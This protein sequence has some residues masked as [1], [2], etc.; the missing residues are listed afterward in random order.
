[1]NIG[2]ISD[3][4]SNFEALRA[5]LSF[6][7][8]EKVEQVICAGDIIGYGAEPNECIETIK[9]VSVLNVYGNHEA[10]LTGLLP[11]E[12][13]NTYAKEAIDWHRNK[14]KTDNFD[15]IHEL[16]LEAVFDKFIKIVH[17]SPVRPQQ[18]PYLI[19]EREYAEALIS[20]REKICIVGHTHAPAVFYYDAERYHFGEISND[21]FLIEGDFK[22]II[23]VGSVGQPRDGDKR[24]CCGIYDYET[25]IFKIRRVEYDFM[26]ARNKIIKAGLPPFLG[27][28]LMYG[29]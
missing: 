29:T 21:T 3:I 16:K 5:V 19:T 6:F 9:N 18:F 24:A 23:N 4:H 14:V 27:E 8:K 26:A 22:Y 25:N 15:F 7:K 20:Y 10:A 12:N 28:R 17:A 11:E 13:F 1:M 2:F